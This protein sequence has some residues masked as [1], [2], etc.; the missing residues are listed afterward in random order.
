MLFGFL[1][2]CFPSQPEPSCAFCDATKE[3]GFNVQYEDVDYIV[4]ND[5]SPA[6]LHHMLVIPRKH[7]VSIKALNAS[8]AGMLRDMERIGTERLDVLDVPQGQRLM[9]FHIPPFNSVD[10]LHLHVFGLPWRSGL[11]HAKYPFRAGSNGDVKG[12]TWFV[13]IEQAIN[14]LESGRRVQVKPC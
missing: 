1:S 8:D 10:H 5:R 13:E 4:L 3:N 6:A 14:I 9:G 12:W 7:V 11:K 2:S